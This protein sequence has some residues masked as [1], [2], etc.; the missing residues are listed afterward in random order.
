MLGALFLKSSKGR[1]ND[2]IK[3]LDRCHEVGSLLRRGKILTIV[4]VAIGEM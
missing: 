4:E 3:L 2:R 1:R